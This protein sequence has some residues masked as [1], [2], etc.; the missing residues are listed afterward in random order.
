MGFHLCSFFVHPSVIRWF[1]KDDRWG[2]MD[3]NI[4]IVCSLLPLDATKS[5]LTIILLSKKTTT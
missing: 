2:T 4:V 5:L 1:K 3:F